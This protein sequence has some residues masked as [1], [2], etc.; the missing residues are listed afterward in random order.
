MDFL[1]SQISISP[2]LRY[3]FL[4]SSAKNTVTGLCSLVLSFFEAIVNETSI[5]FS[6]LLIVFNMPLIFRLPN[7]HPNR[8]VARSAR[9]TGTVQGVVG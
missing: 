9:D 3:E 4:S 5:L 1:F 8:T 6:P 7:A 2:V